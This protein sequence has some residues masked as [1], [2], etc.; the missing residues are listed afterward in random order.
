MAESAAVDV[1]ATVES[2]LSQAAQV[3]ELLSN[4]DISEAHHE[5]LQTAAR[6]FTEQ[7]NLLHTTLDEKIRQTLGDDV[8]LINSS[9]KEREELELS[10]LKA[11][12]VKELLEQAQ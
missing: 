11:K 6:A 12:H 8:P 3:A 4:P 2:M 10:V 1:E 5:A 9:Y 7:S